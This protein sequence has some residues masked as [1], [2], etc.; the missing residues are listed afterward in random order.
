MAERK[1][2][3]QKDPP[4]LGPHIRH[5]CRPRFIKRISRPVIQSIHA[6][7]WKTGPRSKSVLLAGASLLIIGP[8]SKFYTD[9]KAKN[10]QDRQLIWPLKDRLSVCLKFP[11]R[12]F[13]ADFL[14]VELVSFALIELCAQNTS[15]GANLVLEK[16]HGLC[17]RKLYIFHFQLH[18]MYTTSFW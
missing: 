7:E 1:S 18:C 2:L 5:S 4:I 15:E 14:R 9:P 13:I 11:S 16:V 3:W 8:L 6:L 17:P 10:S 12:Q